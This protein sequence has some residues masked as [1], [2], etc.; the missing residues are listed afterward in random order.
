MWTALGY[1]Y[2]GVSV[3]CCYRHKRFIPKPLWLIAVL[4]TV[5]YIYKTKYLILPS[6]KWNDFQI[7]MKSTIGVRYVDWV[8]K[9]QA[10]GCVQP[11]I[12]VCVDMCKGT[13]EDKR[14]STDPE[15]LAQYFQQVYGSSCPP[16]DSCCSG[17]GA[18]TRADRLLAMSI[19]TNRDNLEDNKAAV[20]NCSTPLATP[21]Q[22][23]QAEHKFFEACGFPWAV[24]SEE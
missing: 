16:C 9:L 3:R 11:D 12:K 4:N 22:L 17:G 7:C 15:A 13:P 2:K 1:R 6:R 18:S 21:C 19:A 23:S 10:V 20:I 14:C 5:E 24:D 8:Q